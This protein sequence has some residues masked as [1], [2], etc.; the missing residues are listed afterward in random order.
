MKTGDAPFGPW[1]L[2]VAAA[3][4][5]LLAVAGSVMA[6]RF[7]HRRQVQQ[8]EVDLMLRRELLRSELERHRMLP[9]ALAENPT[10]SVAVDPTV[11]STRRSAVNAALNDDL[12]RL[13][14]ADGA[15]TL[16]LV[17]A[18]GITVAASNHRLPT[19]FV[20]RDY[21]FRAYFRD[22]M[23]H[24]SG[25][26]F[27]QGTVSGVAG[28]YL[29]QRLADRSGVIVAKVEFTDLERNWRT[30][31][32]LTMVVD[33]EGV[34]LLTSD[35]ARRFAQHPTTGPADRGLLEARLPTT[36][37]QWTIVLLR[38]ARR[39][40]L[41]WRLGGALIGG[42]LGLLLALA[43][44][45]TRADRVRR[46][47]TRVELERLVTLRTE[48]LERSNRQLTLEIDERTRSEAKVQRLREEL[49]QANRL[50]ILGQI[51]AG[52]AHEINQPTAAI[53]TFVDNARRL[54]QRGE[55]GQ[56]LEA[57]TTVAGLT[58]RIGLITSELR[59]FSR[60]ST[61]STEPLRL[62]D[63]I[64]GSRL[65]L[66]QSLRSQ[67]IRLL[68]PDA[69]EQQRI[70][71]NKTRVEQVLVIVVQNAIEALVDTPEPTIRLT[72]GSAGGTVW[73]RIEDNGPGIPPEVRDGLFAPFSTTKP[74]GLGLGLVICR[75]I[76]SDLGGS[77]GFEP[78]PSGGA[79]FTLRF[80]SWTP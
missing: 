53:G 4:I 65:L 78:V 3:V 6:Q 23:Q 77:I 66:D 29:A 54:L 56:A 43:F 80:P 35:P 24:G 18:Q 17:D 13:A 26:L 72:A 63:A 33:R 30:G 47:R 41:A 28:L 2:A 58:D 34:V 32:D 7:E 31:K 79:A 25:Q 55:T 21:S 40:V 27:A 75:D 16:Y 36:F 11:P 70:M 69:P 5:A 45:V 49:A 9:T 12:E 52:V 64:D 73:L 60:R 38:D 14:R 20:G 62:A 39:A 1:H 68:R 44:G 51:S 74:L 15:A 67:G 50:A 10:L 61:A 22:A 46:E 19:S 48:A 57:L 8:L 59:G 71:A 42:V 37:D 76:L